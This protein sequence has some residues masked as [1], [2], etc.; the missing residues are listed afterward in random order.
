VCLGFLVLVSLSFFS[1]LH[2]GGKSL[3]GSDTVNWRA[4]ANSVIEYE[5]ATGEAALWAT[6]V[7]GGM[8][9]YMIRYAAAVPQIDTLIGFARRVMWPSSH[10]IVLLAGMYLLVFFLTRNRLAGVLSAV[11]FGLTTYLPILLAT[12]HNSKFVSLCFAPWLLLAFAFALRRPGVLAS[13]LFAVALAVN[14][15]AGHFQIT[16]YVLFVALIWWL[17]EGVAA[18]S[19]GQLSRFGRV[20]ASL[21]FGGVFAGLMVAQPYLAQFEYKA[22]TIRGSAPG[23]AAGGLSWDYA[24]GW[25][26]GVAELLTLA[27]ADAF[28]GSELYWGPKT[29]TA[30]PHY[31]T[32]IVVF[33]AAA[34]V[35]RRREAWVRS[36]GVAAVVMIFFSLG[37]NFAILNRAMF[38][39]FPLFSAFR[40]PETWLAA[41]ALVV[42][43]LAGAGV[44]SIVRDPL[45]SLTLRSPIAIG[46]LALIGGLLVLGLAG[47]AVLSFERPGERANIAQ[48]IARSNNVPDSDPRVAQAAEQVM[49]EA[50]TGRQDKLATDA[51]RSFIF[52]LVAGGLYLLFRNGRFGAPVLQIAVTLLVLVDLWTVDRRYF[53]SDRMT[54]SS[55]VVESIPE[56]AFDRYVKQRADASSDRFR[57]LSLEGAPTQTARPSYFYESLSGYHGAK[58]R[59]YQDF[60]EHILVTPEGRLNVAALRM[61]NTRFVVSRSPIGASAA[62]FEDEQTGFS[63]YELGD[64]LPRAYFVDSLAVTPLADDAWSAL[65]APDFEPARVAFVEETLDIP[66]SRPDFADVPT[67]VVESY[68]PRRIAVRV[69]TQRKRLLVL[70]EVYYPAGW[71]ATIDGDPTHIHRVNYLLRGV[72]VPPGEH[73]VLFAF[74]PASHR[75]GIWISA[76]ST[77]LTYG[78]LLVLGWI[79]VRRRPADFGEVKADPVA[80]ES[81][82]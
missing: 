53:N 44:D 43:V 31:L 72:T 54:G 65:N 19:S 41:V 40:V 27:V 20:S 49:D 69:N 3:A 80:G 37:S 70:S 23:G 29:F 73:E 75:I 33:L 2:F 32:G 12:G 18:Y 1:S 34:A 17:A 21:V 38:N 10:F 51:W 66:A 67:A 50:R 45:K 60:L 28:G 58:L 46:Y 76:A 7:F 6:N 24:M 55:D 71:T 13:A 82:S 57:V 30:G 5:E 16:Y 25:S 14:L 47:D 81:T 9:A 68:G 63:V 61:M 35:V 48:Q 39:F 52:L 11:A 36:L 26:Q 74:E 77:L 4:T 56:F 62:V 64:A 42:A 79:H 59:L 22:Y 78:L 15:R 8:P